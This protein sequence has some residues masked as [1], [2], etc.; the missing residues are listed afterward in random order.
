MFPHF[1]VGDSLHDLHV[2]LHDRRETCDLGSYLRPMPEPGPVCLGATAGGKTLRLIV[3]FGPMLSDQGVRVLLPS[4]T[5]LPAFLDPAGKDA[6]HS[7]SLS[8]RG[9]R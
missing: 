3:G 9:V 8:D 5:D 6:E 4:P 2:H 7:T 1:L